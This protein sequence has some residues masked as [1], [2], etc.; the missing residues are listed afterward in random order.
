MAR[1]EAMLKINERLEALGGN[2]FA[3]LHELLAPVAPRANLAP[4]MLSVGE[5]Q[6]QPPAFMAETI[7]AHADSW[8]RYPPPQGTDEFRAAAVDWLTRRFALKPETLDPARHILSLSGT[9]EGL[10]LTTHMTV[11]SSKAGGRPVVLM[12]NP[13][14]QVYWGAAAMSG[15]EILPLSATAETGFLPD[16]DR[17]PADVLDRTAIAFLCTPANPQGAIADRAYLTRAL[18][19]ARQHDFVL[20]VDECYS[21]IWDKA[22]PPGA[23]EAAEALGGGLDNLLIFHSLSKR[24]NAAGLRAGF[25]AGDERL[26]ERFRTLRGYAGPQLPLPVQ[27]AAATLWRD[28]A[29]VEENRALYRRKIDLAESI[30]GDRFGFYRPAGGFFLWLDVGDSERA[31]AA[32]WREAALRTLPGAYLATEDAR[33]VNPGIPYLRLALVHDEAIVAEALERLVRVLS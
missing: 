23:L 30:L 20:V 24:S 25:V 2:P 14:Y 21:E 8:N 26:I 29:H 11:P 3:R 22:P 10:Y 31:C 32:L 9:K 28:E 13:Y 4:L 12:P 17:V 16:F 19:L 1:N 18:T 33:G 15:A 7:A 27:A 6:H 5:P